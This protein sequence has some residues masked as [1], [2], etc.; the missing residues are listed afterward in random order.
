MGPIGYTAGLVGALEVTQEAVIELMF[1]LGYGWARMEQSL[2][3][4][5][6]DDLVG[7]TPITLAE[8]TLG[9]LYHH[10]S[11]AGYV[12]DVPKFVCHVPGWPDG[13]DGRAWFG[14]LLGSKLS[15]GLTLVGSPTGGLPI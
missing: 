6:I 8:A 1:Q 12:A 11:V 15:P 7:A 3:G 9:I 5:Y 14:E 4:G 10:L 13:P 2:F